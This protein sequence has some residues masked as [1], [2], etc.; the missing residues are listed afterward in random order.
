MRCSFSENRLDEFVD[1]TLSARDRALVAAHVADCAPCTSL[2]EELRVIDALLITPR[3]LDPAPNF[4]FKVMADVRGLPRPHVHRT[5]ALAV[6]G[7][8]VVFAWI[9]IGAYVVFARGAAVA[10]LATLGAWFARI[11]GVADSI[12]RAT[13][14]VFGRQ[15]FDVTAAMGAVLAL[16]AVAAL[17]LVALYGFVRSRRMAI[18]VGEIDR[19]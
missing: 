6:L 8:Y 11:H 7:T 16:D 9:T 2:L 4:T 17:S 10:T 3:T 19:C 13:G 15:V 5:P 14:H 1:G 12:T 18:S